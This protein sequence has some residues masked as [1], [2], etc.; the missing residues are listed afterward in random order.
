MLENLY[1]T[2]MSANKKAMQSRFS[3]IRSKSGRL[4]K[5]MALVMS[6]AIAVTMLCATVVMAAVGNDGLEYWDKNEIYFL[7]SMDF[8]VYA[9]GEN[10]PSWVT[11]D[12]TSRNENISVSIKNYQMREAVTGNVAL[13]TVLELSG[14]KGVTKLYSVTGGRINSAAQKDD[15]GNYIKGGATSSFNYPYVSKY[16]FVETTSDSGLAEYTKPFIEQG[17]LDADTGKRKC[18]YV[19]FGIDDEMNI[20]G[21]RITLC[22]TDESNSLDP[23]NDEF[24]AFDASLESLQTVGGSAKEFLNS[25]WTIYFTEFEKNYKNI[26]N[27]AV[28]IYVEAASPEEIVL[29]TDV[30]LENAKYIDISVMDENGN[31]VSAGRED[32]ADK[33]TLVKDLHSDGILNGTFECGK[34]YRICLGVLDENRNLIYRWQDY[35]TIQ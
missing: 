4:S 24:D 34:Q 32:F 31:T 16:R 10:I 19:E 17:V 33:Y 5:M 23:S 1:T 25:T 8:D 15:N 29:N 35:V 11:E 27:D 21:I 3:K 7:G 13:H 9:A 2:K 12:V 26:E 18:V 22:L 6:I 30:D 20:C 28:N 14:S